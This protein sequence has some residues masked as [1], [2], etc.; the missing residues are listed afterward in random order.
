MN[1]LKADLH[2][3][4]SEDPEDFIRYSA[5]EL[6]DMAHGLGYSVLSITNHNCL[7]FDSFLRDY[8]KERGIILIPGMEA[9]IQRRHVLLYNL[10]FHDIK[11]SD[12]SSLYD[13]KSDDSLI[14][15]PHPYF[16]SPVALRGLFHRYLDLFDAVEYSHFYTKAVNFN[17]KALAIAAQKGLP[18]VGTSD[19]HQRRQ[20]H[21]TYSLIEAEPEIESV[22]DA[23]KKGRVQ[24][25]TQPLTF[26]EA[27]HISF[28]MVFRNQVLQ[29]LPK[30]A[31]AFQK[32]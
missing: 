25:V 32:K 1:L 11:K 14:I 27:M 16:P 28:S 6:I 23:I 20:F 24:V 21:R 8:A 18:V 10:D 19:A 31:V 7:T 3:H 2:I 4:T 30:T 12:L 22:I 5:T 29:Q 26:F 9:T 15:A 13:Q 17:Q